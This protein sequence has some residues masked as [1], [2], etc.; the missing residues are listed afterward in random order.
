MKENIL[1]PLDIDQSGWYLA[2]YEEVDKAKLYAFG[3]QIPEFRLITFADGGFITN[4]DEFSKYFSAII[5]G[6]IG[7]DN[8]LM[9]SDSFKEMLTKQFNEAFE[10]GIFWVVGNKRIGHTGGDPGVTTVAYFKPETIVGIIIFSNS[11][12]DDASKYIG[13][14]FRIVDKYADRIK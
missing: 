1:D 5:S 11:S 10:T 2:D 8:E 14:A 9:S 3:Q 13:D 7:E 4:V 12:S 6:L